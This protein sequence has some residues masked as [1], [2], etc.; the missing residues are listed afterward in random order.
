MTKSCIVCRAVASPDLQLQYCAVCQSALYCSRAC[1][2]EDWKKH[3]KICKLLNVGHGDMQVR[4][5]DHTNGAINLK[6]GLGTVESVLDEVDKRF[7]KLF[8]EST[9]EGSRAAAVEMKKIAKRQPQ[10]MQKVFLFHS[11]HYLTRCDSK[12]LSWPNSP[13]L[14]LLQFV[15][16]NVQS[17]DWRRGRTVGRS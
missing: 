2:R 5:D 8:Q 15:D 16:P 12:K 7:F 10:K 14:G 9:E 6:E 4:D 1:Q 17:G 11:L 3:K 13:L